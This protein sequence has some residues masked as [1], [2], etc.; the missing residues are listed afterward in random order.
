VSSEVRTIAADLERPDHARAV[1]ALTAAYAEDV[2]GNGGALQPDVLDRLVP[3][4]REHP[5]TIVL[6][7]YLGAEPV[8]IA[9]CFLGF[10]TFA[11]RPLINVHD[12]AVLP[13]YRGQGV[14]RALLALIELQ[15]RK[16]GCVKLTLEVQEN[17]H[18]ARRV[19]ER[20]G[21]SHALYGDT[22]GGSLFYAKAL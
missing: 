15:A 5:T 17:N 14:G 6:L 7:A 12:L 20:A 1:V 3:A 13:E 2:M 22:T 4:L 8:G 16:R 21:F 19:Y 10:S 9:T 18:R 11:A